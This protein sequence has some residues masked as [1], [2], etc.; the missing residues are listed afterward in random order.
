M[1]TRNKIKKP[2]IGVISHV[3]PLGKWNVHYTHRKYILPLN[4]T[5]L[6]S[7][8]IPYHDDTSFYRAIADNLD[9]F[10][11]VGAH[12]NV[13]PENYNGDVDDRYGPYDPQRDRVSQVMIEEALLQ[14]KPILGVCR[15]MQDMNV[16]M[17]GSLHQY[18]PDITDVKHHV[19]QYKD[20]HEVY[21]NRHDITLQEGG[22]LKDMLGEE[23]ISVNSVH[24]QGVKDL[25][26]GV[27]VNAIADDGIVEAISLDDHSNFALGLQW[28]PEYD[29]S[30]DP[31]S[32][33][34][35]N[36]FSKAAYKR[37]YEG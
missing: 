3:K 12:S 34:I 20:I 1:T 10:L 28:H 36:E 2:M 11:L 4:N 26:S 35:F 31:H 17:G 19:L 14:N 32:K 7:L 8:I 5:D 33:V 6:C 27:S 29:Y 13:Y 24:K 15:G 25:G 30:Y 9:G 18:L 21:K 23:R 37:K 16:F 22:F